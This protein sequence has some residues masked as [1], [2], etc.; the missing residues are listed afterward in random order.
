MTY[1]ININ[2]TVVGFTAVLEEHDGA[3]D[4]VGPESFVGHG[5]TED[6]ARED[7]E[8]QLSDYER[9]RQADYG[10]YLYEQAKDRRAGL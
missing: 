5:F 10:D 6:E 1:E 2:K 3:P 9:E 8:Q 7:L 4:A